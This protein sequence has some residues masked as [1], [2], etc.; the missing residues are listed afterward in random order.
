MRVTSQTAYDGLI[1]NSLRKWKHNF[2]FI[3]DQSQMIG[4]DR[5]EDTR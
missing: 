1:A 4:N 2:T 3:P 5:K